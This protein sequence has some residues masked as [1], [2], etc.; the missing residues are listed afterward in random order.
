MSLLEEAKAKCRVTSN[1]FNDEINTLILAG[2]ADMKM[3]DINPDN[4]TGDDLGAP[5]KMALMT[6]VSMNFKL[7]NGQIDAQTYTLLKASYD[8]QKSQML[9]STEWGNYNE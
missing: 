1:A 6:Y 9:M 5:I 7:S 4:L 3:T 8:E 2:L